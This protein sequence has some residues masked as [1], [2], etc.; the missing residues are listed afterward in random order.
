MS[1]A[2][3]HRAAHRTTHR[4]TTTSS[5]TITTT[6]RTAHRTAVVGGRNPQRNPCSSL[7]TILNPDDIGFKT[8]EF[9]FKLI[10]RY[11]FNV[12]V[13]VAC[14]TADDAASAATVVELF[15]YQTHQWGTITTLHSMIHGEKK[16]L[17][18][19]Y[20]PPD[21]AVPDAPL[22][23][24]QVKIQYE[25]Q[26][27]AERFTYQFEHEI[28]RGQSAYSS[29]TPSADG[30]PETSIFDLV[31]PLFPMILGMIQIEIFKMFREIEANRY[32]KDT[33][34]REAYKILRMLKS[35]D[36][37]TRISYPT[38]SCQ[39]LNLMTDVKVI[40]GLT[41]IQNPKEQRMVIHDRRICSAE[42]EVFNSGAAI[43]RK[44]VH[45]EEEYEE[46]AIRV[47][48]AAK[49]AAAAA[50]AANPDDHEHDHEHDEDEDLY[51]EVDDALPSRI[52]TVMPIYTQNDYMDTPF[53]GTPPSSHHRR[54]N[55]ITSNGSEVRALCVRIATARNNKEDTSA[56]ELY[57]Q[58]QRP[59]H[60]GG[61]RNGYYDPD[62]DAP[63]YH[64]GADDTFSSTPMDD[65]YTQ[66]R[67]GMMRQMSA[68]K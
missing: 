49:T 57:Q 16:T 32:D 66:R 34:V 11:G 23:S 17:W 36:A 18:V 21:D 46:E 4:T 60:G 2:T 62:E 50:T 9:L 59:R 20:T 29:S 27:T 6:H 61:G 48:N 52:P 44:Y 41:T 68:H 51:E 67:V 15:E 38:I 53:H 56:E 14:T 31:V 3:T 1:P 35:I 25:N 58:M 10:M 33:I 28:I 43:S 64:G 8:G 30:A 42:Q 45:D 22:P 40:I 55:N 24:V 65:E 5:S 39:T 19:Q 13:S 54:R 63:Y 47:I 7:I 26:F 37:I 12:Q